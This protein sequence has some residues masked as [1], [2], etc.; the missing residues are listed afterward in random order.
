[1]LEN[2]RLHGWLV[3]A[4]SI[5]L[6][7][8]GCGG[9]S[10]ESG[11]GSTSAPPSPPAATPAP[12]VKSDASVATGDGGEP[13]VSSIKDL[14]PGAECPDPG[15][16]VKAVIAAAAAAQVPLKVGLT[17][18][19][20]WKAYEGDYE[21]ECLRQVVAIDERSV[22][23]TNSCR[24]VEE[25]KTLVMQRRV[26][27]KDFM[28]SY[29]YMP[30]FGEHV[31]ETLVGA[32][33]YSASLAS[34]KALKDRGEMHH[35]LVWLNPDGPGTVSGAVEGMLTSDGA[36]TFK[37]IINDKRVEVPTIE[38]SYVN[39]SNNDIVR[40]KILDDA[41]FPLMLDHYL[42][43]EKSY[44]VTYTKVSF[45]TDNGVEQQLALDKRTDVYGIYFNF[46][47]DELRPESEPVLREIAAAL[48]A[49][50]D[51]KL[52][53]NGHTDNIGNDA[54]N[55][56]LSRRRAVAVRKALVERF[57]IDASKLL[58]DGFGASQPKEAN[59][60]AGGRAL[61]RRVE[62]VRQ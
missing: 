44:F 20:V 19:H 14:R 18:S 41:R 47:S 49:H 16:D 39:H 6:M 59:D 30:G 23:T 62:L 17:L 5:P 1:M 7:L 46:A 54:A 55:L 34:F 48:L 29:L 32:L 31:P 52:T 33:A 40:V 12:S 25:R 10:P 57:Q 24:H 43:S 27:W 13:P 53:V 60:T 3:L 58:T 2:P 37:L 9:S 36:S 56:D 22:A 11:A 50:P 28:D 15:P 45:P 38:A 61:N 4:A 21:H 35:R 42:P 8:A 26:C 51:W